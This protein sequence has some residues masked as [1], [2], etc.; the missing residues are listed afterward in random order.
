MFL[1]GFIAILQALVLPGLLVARHMPWDT[2][3]SR[4][5]GVFVM[6]QLLN[7]WL[8]VTLTLFEEYRQT[9]MLLIVTLE[10][11]VILIQAWRKG[12]FFSKRLSPVSPS[13]TFADGVVLCV[14]GAHLWNWLMA[15][16]SVFDAHDAIASWYRWAIDWA[17]N[18][19]PAD[20]LSYPQLVPVSLSIPHRLMKA[21]QSELFAQFLMGAY[22]MAMFLVMHDL[23]RRWSRP[24][25]AVM[26]A[27]TLIFI[28][29]F[30]HGDEF[31]AMADVP[32]AALS[33]I[34]MAWLLIARRSDDG[35]PWFRA[36]L[37]AFSVAIVCKQGALLIVIPA[38]VWILADKRMRSLLWRRSNLFP[39]SILILSLLHWYVVKNLISSSDYLRVAAYQVG[40]I[41]EGRNL[42]E[43]I[44]H[45]LWSIERAFRPSVMA[46]FF[47]LAGMLAALKG[48]EGRLIFS[49]FL[50]PFSVWSLAYCYDLRNLSVALPF[51][52]M[53]GAIGFGYWAGWLVNF[54]KRVRSMGGFRNRLC[55]GGLLVLGISGL[56]S[57]L[58]SPES[59]HTALNRA[60]RQ[61]GEPE[62]NRLI[63]KHINKEEKLLSS[64]LQATVQ[65]GLGKRVQYHA[66]P[67]DPDKKNEFDKDMG[68]ILA[69]SHL[70]EKESNYRNEL[71][72]QGRIQQ[73]EEVSGW[74][75]YRV[76]GDLK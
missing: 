4:V 48:R 42:W 10:V 73:F 11:V 18:R 33:F 32:V 46:P 52:A 67:F 50:V 44:L 41:H 64:Y 74:V 30:Y 71:L 5:A 2:W 27:L 15:T 3:Q 69:E 66:Y 51:A 21:G 6:S 58:L 36:G 29:L 14:F 70:P 28:R 16:G 40:D 54:W 57:L 34:G 59:L 56:V 45:G 61:A 72:R 23:M 26:P 25:L 20:V 75:L 12:C 65:Q 43:R 8:V 7:Y 49:F 37:F 60:K 31:D 38:T 68:W 17:G 76:T 9:A 22:P 63:L 24:W 13:I 62:V 53:A 55:L 35:A 1:L 39:M 19:F 47:I